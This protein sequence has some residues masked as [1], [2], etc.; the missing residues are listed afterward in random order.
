MVVWEDKWWCG[1]MNGGVG[2]W[3]VVWEDEWWCGRMNGGVGG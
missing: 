3:M 1:R 2:G